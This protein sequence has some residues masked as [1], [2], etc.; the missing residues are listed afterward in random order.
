MPAP[1]LRRGGRPTES[2]GVSAVKLLGLLPLSEA[3]RNETR[4]TQ[5]QKQKQKP[6]T[7]RELPIIILNTCQMS[8]LKH[9]CDLNK[10]EVR[11]EDEIVFAQ[12]TKTTV[13]SKIFI[14]MLNVLFWNLACYQTTF[15]FCLRFIPLTTD[16][17]SPLSISM[18]F[19]L[20]LLFCVFHFKKGLQLL[21]T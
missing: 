20:I 5:K 1:T 21:G 19:P 6:Q 8:S 10:A 13:S 11:K 3:D 9:S 2:R 15:K 17:K 7:K 16:L 18:V 12:K 14:H 4:L